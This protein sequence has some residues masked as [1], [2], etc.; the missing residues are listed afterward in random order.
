MKF[1]VQNVEMT[2]LILEI[3]NFRAKMEVAEL[4]VAELEVEEL[5]VAG[6]EVQRKND[7]CN[8]EN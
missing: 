1:S 8:V 3:E 5:E 2:N 6:L 4:E 7:R